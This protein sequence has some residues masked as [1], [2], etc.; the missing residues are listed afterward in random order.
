VKRKWSVQK[1]T[2][3]PPD[4]RLFKVSSL[5]VASYYWFSGAEDAFEASSGSS[6]SVPS[7]AWLSILS[8]TL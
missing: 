8:P 2:R 5:T 4:E 7:S 1:D 6:S 3:L